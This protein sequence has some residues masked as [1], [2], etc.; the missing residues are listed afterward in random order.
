MFKFNIR[1]DFYRIENGEKVSRKKTIVAYFVPE[2]NFIDIRFDFI[3]PYDKEKEFDI[4]WYLQRLIEYFK[5]VFGID[6]VYLELFG[7][8]HGIKEEND[9]S[10]IGQE[11]KLANGSIATLQASSTATGNSKYVL[12]FLGELQ[13]LLADYQNELENAPRFKEAFEKFLDDK[14]VTSDLPWVIIKWEDETSTKITFDYK[15][16]GF[17]L[18]QHYSNYGRG[19]IGMERMNRVAEYIIEYRASHPATQPD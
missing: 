8:E 18:I 19:V 6:I 10:I 9:K 3:S 5:E 7:L 12:P 2:K 4:S 14:D 17:C 13:E 1:Q 15:N 11:M 16:K